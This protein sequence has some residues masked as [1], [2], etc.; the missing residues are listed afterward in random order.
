MMTMKLCICLSTPFVN[1]ITPKLLM[2]LL[3][4]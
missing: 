2:K 4:D 1:K 3:E